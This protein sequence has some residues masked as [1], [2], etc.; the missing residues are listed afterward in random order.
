MAITVLELQPLRG[1]R[2][3]LASGDVI[4]RGPSCEVRLDDPLVSRRHALISGRDGGIAIE[5]L[6][7]ANGLYVNG[8]RC[9]GI[10]ALCAGDV[11]QLGGTIWRVLGR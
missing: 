5:D 1:R 3:E 6:G 4:G 2:L 9:T 10:E 11:V 8:G 7:S